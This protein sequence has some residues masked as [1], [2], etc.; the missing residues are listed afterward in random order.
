[1]EESQ[2]LDFLTNPQ[3]RPARSGG[4]RTWWAH[5][6]LTRINIE[7]IFLRKKIEDVR[8]AGAVIAAREWTP[9]DVESTIAD[10]G[11]F[12]SIRT[13]GYH[14]IDARSA[15]IRKKLELNF[16]RALKGSGA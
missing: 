7:P 13:Q 16:E 9:H 5:F 1:M 15:E 3:R 10:V 6:E 4:G 8:E 11:P 2:D 14:R 12:P